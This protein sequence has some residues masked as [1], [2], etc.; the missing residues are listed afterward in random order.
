MKEKIGILLVHGIGDQGRFEHIEEVARNFIEAL[1][2]SCDILVDVKTASMGEFKSRKDVWLQG[3]EG[4][5]VVNSRCKET[6]REYELHFREVWWAHHGESTNLKTALSFWFW[7]ISLWANVFPRDEPNQSHDDENISE[8]ERERKIESPS[9]NG[10][11]RCGLFVVCLLVTGLMPAL[12]LAKRVLEVIGVQL[13]LDIISQ[14]LSKVKLYQQDKRYTKEPITNIGESP[15]VSIQREMV[16]EL[17]EMAIGDYDRW[18]VLGHSLGSVIAYNGLF[19]TEENLAKY[20]SQEDWERACINKLNKASS[21]EGGSRESISPLVSDSSSWRESGS[22]ID[23]KNLF[24]KLKGFVTY[25]SPL[26]KYSILWPWLVRKNS[27]P[28]VFRQDFEWINIYDPLDP[29]ASRTEFFSKEIAPIE[30]QEFAYSTGGWHLDC[31]LKYFNYIDDNSLVKSVVNWIHSGDR[32]EDE[33]KAVETKFLTS[34]QEKN[35]HRC[36]RGKTLVIL[37]LFPFLL[38]VFSIFAEILIMI[39]E[40]HPLHGVWSA[41]NSLPKLAGHFEYYVLYFGVIPSIV[42]IAGL[43]S[44]ISNKSPSQRSKIIKSE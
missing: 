32:F 30:P 29:V 17:V 37:F 26:K 27:D 23:R 25:G 9:I 40:G 36:R 14:Y 6:N 28:H 41:V 38:G 33:A 2:P 5:V 43:L 31:H 21:N 22:A 13:R 20:L 15:R 39:V 7:G 42:F 34:I 3:E 44:S 24:S 18:Y 1:L 12:G 16:S 10:R 35:K 4:T 8:S 19:E 11:E